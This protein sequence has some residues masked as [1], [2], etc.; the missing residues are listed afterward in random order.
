MKCDGMPDVAN[1]G[2]MNTYLHLWN[3]KIEA[4]DIEEASKRTTEVIQLL[5][6]LDDLINEALAVDVHQIEDWKWVKIFHHLVVVNYYFVIDLPD[7]T[8]V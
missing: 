1:C 6:V 3:M 7:K 2:Q 8:H 4:T 5:D